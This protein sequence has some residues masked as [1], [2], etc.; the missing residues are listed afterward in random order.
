M[1]VCCWFGVRGVGG[2]VREEGWL[3]WYIQ[4]DLGSRTQ[5]HTQ[6]SESVSRHIINV[7]GIPKWQCCI[8]E[9]VEMIK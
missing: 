8:S 9:L 2:E 5:N 4:K 3:I 6:N 1:N 7:L